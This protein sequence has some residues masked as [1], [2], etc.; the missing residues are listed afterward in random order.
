MPRSSLKRPRPPQPPGGRIGGEGRATRVRAPG[1]RA[2]RGAL[3]PTQRR[4]RL[5]TMRMNVPAI[6][7]VGLVAFVMNSGF[8]CSSSEEDLPKWQYGEAEMTRAVE[9]TWRLTLERPAGESAVTFSLAP[10]APSASSSLTSAPASYLQCGSRDFI[11]PAGACID[12]STLYLSGQV[13]VAEAALGTPVVTG[14]YTVA[15]VTYRG[16]SLN[17]D[18]GPTLHMSATLDAGDQVTETYTDQN[19]ARIASRL[20]RVE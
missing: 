4:A 10:G 18:L 16:G 1:D 11:R 3:R 5:V 12:I 20:E 15:G 7:V 17:I 2:T 9:G 14:F 6:M 8:A 13:L 19:H